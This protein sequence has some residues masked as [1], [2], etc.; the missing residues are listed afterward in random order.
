MMEAINVAGTMTKKFPAVDSLFFKIQ[1]SKE[2]IDATAKLVRQITKKHG[3]THFEFAATEEE[4]D[5]LWEGRK[6]AL[7]SYV[8]GHPGQKVWTTDVWSVSA[9]F[10]SEISF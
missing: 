1:G 3:C 4:A 8:S 5:N 7:M 6:Y 9:H 10:S 2:A